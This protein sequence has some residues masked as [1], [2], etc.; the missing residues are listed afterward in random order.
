LDENQTRAEFNYNLGSLIDSSSFR[1]IF[2]KFLKKNE[3]METVLEYNKKYYI[4]TFE[5]SAYDKLKN[6][7]IDFCHK[8]F[9]FHFS[10]NYKDLFYDKFSKIYLLIVFYYKEKNYW[11]FGLLFFK[12]YN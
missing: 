1:D 6:F 11:K 5:N 7:T 8:E 10:L 2:K 4:Y 3:M 9:Y 12:K